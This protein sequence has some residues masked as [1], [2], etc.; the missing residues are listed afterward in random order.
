MLL[1]YATEDN[2][3]VFFFITVMKRELNWIVV[4]NNCYM[5]TK[6]VIGL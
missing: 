5:H 2:S 3:F 1:N 4:T 6:A